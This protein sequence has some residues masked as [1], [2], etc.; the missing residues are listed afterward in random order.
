MYVERKRIA[1]DMKNMSVDI[2]TKMQSDNSDVAVEDIY[3]PQ[4]TN[5]L[6]SALRKSRCDAYALKTL[7]EL[8]ESAQG[9][10]YSEPFLRSGGLHAL[11]DVLELNPYDQMSCIV[12]AL[13]L[14]LGFSKISHDNKIEIC[15][16]GIISSLV[17]L[18]RRTTFDAFYL[19]AVAILSELARVERPFFLTAGIGIDD[20]DRCHSVPE[21]LTTLMDSPRTAVKR[22]ALRLGLE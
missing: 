6:K 15:D 22:V 13:R 3:I 8:F 19:L 20:S 21:A 18:C 14:I 16:A 2:M 12:T 10:M 4:L 17:L 1:F 7:S 5:T 11:R 9:T